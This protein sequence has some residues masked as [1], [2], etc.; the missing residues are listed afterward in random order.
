MLKDQ[1]ETSVSFQHLSLSL[2][3]CLSVSIS[4]SLCLSLSLSLPLLLSI[5][6]FSLLSLSLENWI[7]FSCKNVFRVKCTITQQLLHNLWVGAP[8]VPRQ[9][10]FA[11]FFCSQRNSCLWIQTLVYLMSRQWKLKALFHTWHVISLLICSS[12]IIFYWIIT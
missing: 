3:L 2:C 9:L 11:A 4:V 8:A 7:V 5:S 12:L 10:C 6:F 1:I